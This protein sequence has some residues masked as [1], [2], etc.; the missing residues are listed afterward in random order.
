MSKYTDDL[1]K[2]LG[3]VN[4]VM[5]SR[6]YQCPL[7]IFN[8]Q[9]PH[10]FGT[11]DHRAEVRHFRDRSWW[12]SKPI[13]I[14]GCG[15]LQESRTAHLEAAITWA[16]K[17]D[18]GVEEWVTTGFANSWIPKAVKAELAADLKK[19]RAAQGDASK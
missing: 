17:R 6:Y 2:A 5:L 13:R 1:E 7:I 9:H 14:R 15:G 8:T 19:W 11:R 18:L 10:A 12:T 3:V 4:P 16:Q